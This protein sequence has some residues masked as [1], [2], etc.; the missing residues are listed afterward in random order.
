M[1]YTKDKR[2]SPYLCFIRLAVIYGTVY[3]SSP[4][5]ISKWDWEEIFL[6]VDAQSINNFRFQVKVNSQKLC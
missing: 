5:R 3:L 2:V 4:V 1:N 6:R